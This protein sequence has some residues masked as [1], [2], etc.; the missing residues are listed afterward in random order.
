MVDPVAHGFDQFGIPLMECLGKFGSS[1]F[2]S[3]FTFLI[4]TTRHRLQS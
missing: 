3:K 2:P 4:V 1:R